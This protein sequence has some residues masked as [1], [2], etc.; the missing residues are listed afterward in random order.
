MQIKNCGS[1][2]FIENLKGR[3][4]ICFGAGARMIKA[5]YAVNHIE[6]HIAFFVDNDE[7]KQ[8]L[9]FQYL[10]RE[11]DIKSP[12]V[13]KTL[14]TKD[15]VLLITCGSYIEIYSQLKDIAELR[16][17]E[18]YIYE[19]MCRY[20]ETDMEQFFTEE[21]QNPAFHDWKQVLERHNLKNKHRGRR[22]FLIGNGPSLKAEDLELLKDEITFAAN[23]IYMLFDKTKWRPTYYFCVDARCYGIDHRK[24]KEMD[25]ELRFVP[26]NTGVMA[27]K[28]YD[29][30]TYYNRKINYVEVNQG[31]VVFKSEVKFSCDAEKAVYA[32][33][34]VL[35]D[36]LQWAVY[37][38]FSE[39]YLLG[40][41]C[42]YAYEMTKDGTVVAT[43][44]EKSHFDE[45]Y[46][47]GFNGA[48]EPFRMFTA[49][50]QAKKSCEEK[51]IVIKNATRGGK[52]DI[53]ERVSL[54][55]IIRTRKTE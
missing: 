36:A 17:M 14:D 20:P 25:A 35:Y 28:V 21:L 46:E 26:L 6:N 2:E 53:F 27:G 15:Y 23:R 42:S 16:D 44:M 48:A 47:T 40:V 32:G 10:G 41:D 30:V 38:G 24:I 33:G 34:T 29:E 49:W 54:E 11:F 39:I 12:D 37:M 55:D 8:G 43:D 4:V 19:S 31:N 51:G 9:T 45:K 7:K 1:E 18:C 3:K 13:L 52:L 5:D 22:C 50:E